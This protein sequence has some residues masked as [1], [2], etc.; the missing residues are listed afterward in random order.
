MGKLLLFFLTNCSFTAIWQVTALEATVSRGGK[1]TV[2][3]VESLTEM[4][5]AN[6]VKLD[7]I[8][9]D[10]DLKLQRRVQ[11]FLDLLLLLNLNLMLHPVVI[12]IPYH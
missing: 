2:M 8:V 12:I 3:D 6:L 7:E 11:V 1:I 10:G 9:V 4:L 5:M